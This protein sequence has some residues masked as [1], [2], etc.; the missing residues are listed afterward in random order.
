[1]EVVAPD[2]E[3][4]SPVAT[5]ASLL[6]AIPIVRIHRNS[7]IDRIAADLAFVQNGITDMYA[8][9]KAM[10]KAVLQCSIYTQQ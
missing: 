8:R 7:N 10:E 9:L 2:I 1:M 6:I 4:S 3:A 5:A